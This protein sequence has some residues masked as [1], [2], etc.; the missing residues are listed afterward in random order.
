MMA[1]LNVLSCS[2]PGFAGKRR[3]SQH[4]VL[5]CSILFLVPMAGLEP[6]R[7]APLTPQASVST[8]STTSAIIIKKPALTALTATAAHLQDGQILLALE[9]AEEFRTAPAR[10]HWSVLRSESPH[11]PASGWSKRTQ[12]PKPPSSGSGKTLN[13]VNQTW[14]RKRHCRRPRPHP[15]PCPAVTAPKRSE[16][17][18]PLHARRERGY[19]P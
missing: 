14:S 1:A 7:L 11:R 5:E 12:S 8:S 17:R 3:T 15:R 19:K 16:Q 13:P 10:S 9:Q 6:A 18:Q 2:F 4:I